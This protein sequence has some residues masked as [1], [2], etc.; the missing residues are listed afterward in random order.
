MDCLNEELKKLYKNE[1]QLENDI[2]IYQGGKKYCL[3][4]KLLS[5]K[6]TSLSNE[7]E[8]IKKLKVHICGKSDSFFKT[9]QEYRNFHQEMERNLELTIER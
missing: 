3:E 5:F 6:K 7:S 1:E 9:L 8:L 2:K 4:I